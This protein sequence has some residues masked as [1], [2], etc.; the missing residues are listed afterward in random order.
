VASQYALATSGSK[1]YSGAALRAAGRNAAS[2]QQQN[3]AQT[4]VLRA[5]EEAATRTELGNALTSTRGADLAAATNEADL[6]LRAGIA[7]Q[8][9]GLE[10]GKAN[11][12]A[13]IDV[14]KAN[15][16]AA[17]QKS[18]ADAGFS[19]QAMLHMSDQELQTRLA[20]A[21]FLVDQER[22]DDLRAYQH[23]QTLLQAQGQVLSASGAAAG[24]AQER[25]LQLQQLQQQYEA[26][27]QRGDQAT[28]QMLA[29]GIG[30]Y[31]GGPAGA[32]AGHAV[33]SGG[34]GGDSSYINATNDP[35]SNLE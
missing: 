23:Q 20:N 17:L 12:T 9:A 1:G 30:Y 32:A 16:G 27:R 11:Q 22:I 21:G 18:L 28:M 31:L 13:Y 4:G 3:N 35:N 33:T 15:Q 8:G 6:G 25:M 34:G 29:T 10:A 14:Q 26:A 24:S 7:N 19:Q 5:Q 2:L